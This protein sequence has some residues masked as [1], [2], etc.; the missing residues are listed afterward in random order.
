VLSPYYRIEEFLDA[1]ND[2]GFLEIINLAKTEVSLVEWG[3]T[4]I[5]RIK[6]KRISGA[7][8]YVTVLK[9]FLFFT[10]TCIKLMG[11]Y[12]E[13][14]NLSRPVI[15]HLVKKKFFKPEMSDAFANEKR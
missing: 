2:K 12:N 5:K 4:G 14:F 10:K 6:A 15:A 3:L 7:P 13:N 11:V 9:G 1:V 8:E